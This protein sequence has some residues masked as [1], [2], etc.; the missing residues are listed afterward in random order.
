MAAENAQIQPGDTVAIWGCGPVGQ[1]AIRSALM[2]G[3]GRVIA[4]DE[5][6]ERLAMARSRRRRDDRFFQSRCL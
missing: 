2:M 5:V 6:P 3:A 4:I 1:F